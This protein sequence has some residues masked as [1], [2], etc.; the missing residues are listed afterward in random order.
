MAKGYIP[1][2]PTYTLTGCVLPALAA[3]SMLYT[4]S[5]VT[6]AQY[7]SAACTSDTHSAVYCAP[8]HAN[9]MQHT[10][11]QLKC[12]KSITMQYTAALFTYKVGGWSRTSSGCL[13]SKLQCPTTL[14]QHPRS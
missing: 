9:T 8:H 6:N 3:P 5:I 13:T 11:I 14:H 10:A 1:W 4:R 7:I 2:S 12:Y